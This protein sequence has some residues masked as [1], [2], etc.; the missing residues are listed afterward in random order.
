M[1]KKLLLLI[2]PLVLMAGV[3]KAETLYT[4]FQGKL[5]SIAERA[6]LSDDKNYTGTHEQNV[7]LLDKL[8]NLLGY[9]VVS[10]YR[11]T[12]S[13]PVTS[14]QTSIPVSSLATKDGHT[15]TM[16]DLGDRVFLTIEPGGAKEEIV[17]CTTIS[18]TAWAT[19]TRGLAFYGTAMTAVTA[20][21]KTHS[22]GSVI[23][24]SNVHY[25]YDQ[26]VDK[27]A[28]ETIAG[29]KTYTT[30][31]QIPT[32]A[33]TLNAEVASKKYVD[34]T[35]NAGAANGTET[36]K[37]IWQG[38]T[39]DDMLSGIAVGS[40]GSYLVLQ[41][42]YATSTAIGDVMVPVTQYDGKLSQSFLRLSDAFTFTNA[43]TTISGRLNASTSTFTGAI[44]NSSTAT[45]SFAGDLFGGG[46]YHIS[47][48]TATSTWSV[49][50]GVKKVKVQVI[51]GGGNSAACGS[52]VVSGGGGGG[53]YAMKY[54]DVSATSSLAIKVNGATASSTVSIS[55]VIQVQALGG[56]SSGGAVG[57]D[58]GGAGGYGIGGDINAYGSG[59]G[60]GYI[61]ADTGTPGFG[62]IGGS[63]WFGGGGAGVQQA[64]SQVSGNSGNNY[65]GGASGCSA[66]SGGSA[67]GASGAPGVVIIEW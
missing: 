42:R 22:A 30:I 17:M 23:T 62:G 2:I 65:G 32:T 10:A 9:S 5:P 26:L 13:S 58:N 57:G 1:K 66:K 27:D 49:P 14:T 4:F 16:A 38:S 51:G 47:A 63:S 20:N 3:V 7:R 33:P 67:N 37:G 41:G 24:I 50:T 12:L 11:T 35:T 40:T 28:A 18:G 61:D 44:T 8:K 43:T 31:P 21:Q 39:Q 19:C 34:D 52:G 15:L 36:V 25:V 60:I 59:G 48:I 64:N 55:G 29:L 45:S 56:S 53:G 46:F 6:K 54:L